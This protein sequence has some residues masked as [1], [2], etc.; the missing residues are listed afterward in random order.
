M[1]KG[2]ILVV[3]D[4]NNIGTTLEGI[5]TDEGYEVSK[6]ENGL[7]ALDM[8]KRVPPDVVLLDIWMPGMDG[9]EVLKSIKE[10]ESD[11]EVVIMSGHGSI[12]TAV[13]AIKLGAFDFIEKPLSLDSLLSTINHAL[14]RQRTAKESQE[15]KRELLQR[16][17][18][19][20][21]NPKI[22]EAR[23]LISA[24]AISNAGVLIEGEHGTGK[25]LVARTIHMNGIRRNR[26]FVKVNCAALPND[27]IGNEMFG[28]DSNNGGG[29][30]KRGKFE[31]A[32]DGT[33]FLDGI[34]KLDIN[35]QET[36]LK[37]LQTGKFMRING[38]RLLPVNFRIIAASEKN[39]QKL[40][41]ENKFSSELYSFISTFVIFL[42]PLRDRK[43]DIP[44]LVN[45]FSRELTQDYG[46]G[47]KEIDDNAMAALVTFNW[48]GNVKEIKNIIERLA[49]SV[50]TGR[51][52][53]EDIPVSIRGVTPKTSQYQYSGYSLKDARQKWEKEYLVHCLTMKGWDLKKTAKEMGITCKTLEKH[54][55]SFGLKKPKKETTTAARIQRTLKT[56]VVLCGQGLHSGLK[57]GLILVPQNPNTGIV[58]AN[59]STGETMTAVLDNV[60][61]TDYATSLKCGKSHVKTIEHI[62]AVLNIYGIN[63]LLIKITDEV[64]IMDGSSLDFCELIEDGGILEQDEFIEEIVIDRVI[65]HGKESPKEKYIKI[66]PCDKFSVKYIMDYP[67]PIGKQEMDYVFKGAEDFKKN[68]APARTFGFLKDVEYLEK[69]GL[70]SGGKLHNVILLDNEKVINTELRF[71]NEFARHKVLDIIGDFYLLGRPLRGK[72]TAHLTGHSENIALLNKIRSIY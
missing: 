14:E 71:K 61:S 66:E 7:Q 45:Y 1:R 48:P 43:D 41:E 54:I 8:I 50:P 15:L 9:I 42:P 40:I 33:L 28:C 29:I 30:S 57:T 24:A 32:E 5:L 69:K 58:F 59:V 27:I 18:L 39:I 38:K 11:T 10:H 53:A 6:A 65:V 46:R 20:G 4:E 25:E 2:H 22:Q 16:Y 68:I 26:P 19:I 34:E 72:I 51:I 56:S 21:E 35:V 49:I 44:S 67:P 60:E 64:P 13:R 3:D 55:K 63:N 31:L 37:V 47:V 23:K 62:M 52:S 12:D 70:I 17:E 36:I